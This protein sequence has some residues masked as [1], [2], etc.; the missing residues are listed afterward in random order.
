[1]R[2][3]YWPNM[4]QAWSSLAA[5]VAHA[6]A[7]GWYGVYLTDHFMGDGGGFGRETAPTLE[8][9][10]GLAALAG[11]TERIRLSSLVMSA[12]Y[13]HPA[14]LANW[15]ATVDQVSNGRLTLGLGAG[16]QVNEHEQ[17]GIE[18]GSPGERRRRLDE[19]LAVVRSLLRN[20]RTTLDGEHF[21]LSDAV[22]EPKPVQQP[23]PVLVGAKGD[24]M[25]ELVARQADVWN[26]WSLPEAIA[27]R[28]RVLDA[29]CEAIG[30]D[31]ATIARTTQA[32]VFLTDD[33]ARAAELVQS[34]A[35]RAAVAGPA[36]VFADTVA[37]WA[38]I[39]VS[40]VIVPDFTLGEGARRAEAMDALREAVEAL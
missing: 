21:S 10:A 38:E 34:V 28:S 26:M 18:L 31:P 11:S 1:M 19:Y 17:Y 7:T 23:L 8:C 40:E 2:L 13:R 29:A 25:L 16:W 37:A 15:A 39:G 22:C 4:G 30:R 24:R 33:P 9:T 5:G 20:E 36:S 32:L 12:T 14:V 27:E 3:G 35:P 6:E